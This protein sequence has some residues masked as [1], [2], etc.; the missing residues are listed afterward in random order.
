M[1]AAERAAL[2]A[3]RTARYEARKPEIDALKEEGAWPP[4]SQRGRLQEQVKEE[5]KRGNNSFDWYAEELVKR[6]AAEKELT[7]AKAAWQAEREELGKE[8]AGAKKEAE[9]RASRLEAELETV[10]AVAGAAEALV[11]AS[12][13]AE[14]ARAA[15]RA[16]REALE[17]E[18]D[19]ESGAEAERWQAAWR[20]VIDGIYKHAEAEPPDLTTPPGREEAH[21]FAL[22]SIGSA[23]SPEG[24]WAKVAHALIRAAHEHAGLAGAKAAY[25]A[26][27]NGGGRAE[28]RA[29]DLEAAAPPLSDAQRAMLGDVCGRN[30][31]E[32]DLG[33]PGVQLLAWHAF[34]REQEER[35][36]RKQ[37]EGG[38]DGQR[39]EAG[40]RA[41]SERT[42][43]GD[44]GRSESDRRTDQT[45]GGPGT[46]ARQSR[47][48]AAGDAAGDPAAPE[49]ARRGRESRWRNC[50]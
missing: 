25:G 12:E 14:A 32:G 15:V 36:K 41:G 7:G 33:D 1:S 10:R 27:M 37:K 48:D 22:T 24:G 43:A 42:E 4:K 30:G 34:H 45:E 29:A 35:E 44:R 19:A 21:R 50:P 13:E 23:A 16:D 49:E 20:K 46:S 5:R 9:D 40:G 28:E 47:G 11:Q 8:L 39:S 3:G 18:R 31:I 26:A 38:H 17:T 2:H 6:N